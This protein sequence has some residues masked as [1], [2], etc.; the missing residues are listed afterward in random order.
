MPAVKGLN[1]LRRQFSE[2]L[3]IVMGIVALVLLIGCANV[4]NL[5]LARASARQNEM[6]VRLAIGAS[7]GRLIRQLLT[8][9]A[10]LVFLG[11]VAGL[12]T[13]RWGVSFLVGL[14]AGPGNSILL[15]PQFDAR[16]LAFT[17]TVAVLTALLF[18]LAP[19]L[20][21]TRVD[22]A[23][24]AAAGT[25]LAGTVA[26]P[27]G[28]VARRHSGHAVRRACSPAPRCSCGRCTISTRWTLDFIAKAC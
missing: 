28:P 5:L 14:L 8:E 10:V 6:S 17:A 11:A 12:V 27:A 2:P 18:S 20:H 1:G 21:A 24:P 9:G 26:H 7:R 23:K 13:A 22:A 25:H 16:V 4:A 19:A 3:L 15:N